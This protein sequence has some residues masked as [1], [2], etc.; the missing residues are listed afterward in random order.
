MNRCKATG[1]RRNIHK[2][3]GVKAA[4]V[5]RLHNGVDLVPMKTSKLRTLYRFLQEDAAVKAA[6][7]SHV[8]G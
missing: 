5:A 2:V 6:G 7:G 1:L 3:F 4:D 8:Q